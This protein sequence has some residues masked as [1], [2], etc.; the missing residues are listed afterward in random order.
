MLVIGV[1]CDPGLCFKGRQEKVQN[2]YRVCLRNF[3]NQ[4]PVPRQERI[5]LPAAGAF[6]LVFVLFLLLSP[7]T[8]L[9]I[10]LHCFLSPS[11]HV[12]RHEVHLSGAEG[13]TASP[14]SGLT[15]LLWLDKGRRPGVHRT[16][17]TCLVMGPATPGWEEFM[18]AQQW[19]KPIHFV[20][21]P[22]CTLSARW[23]TLTIFSSF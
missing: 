11:S 22:L 4:L 13:W 21:L 7:R 3:E 6:C 18:Q 20:I 12:T 14:H 10:H 16:K 9:P 17:D 5:W 2:N 15:E 19:D 8:A 23:R 1:R